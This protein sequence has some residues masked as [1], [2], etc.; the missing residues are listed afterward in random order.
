M[1]HDELEAE[2][3]ARVL[4]ELGSLPYCRL[5]RNPVGA[6][7]NAAGRWLAY[8]LA[9][10]SADYVGIYRGLF[11]SIETKQVRGKTASERRKQQQQWCDMINDQGGIAVIAYGD[12]A[13]LTR[14]IES[15]YEK[16]RDG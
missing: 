1:K 6:V 14:D 5:W 7:Q 2:F 4:L 11:L 13:A 12:M 3:G 15:L 9:K 10:G 8:G 16:R